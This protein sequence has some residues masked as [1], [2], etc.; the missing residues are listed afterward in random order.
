MVIQAFNTKQVDDAAMNAGLWIACPVNDTADPGMHDRSGTHGARLQC[1]EQLAARQTVITQNP[2]C[3]AQSGDFGMRCWIAL[4]DWRIEATSDN[5][6][7]QD[8]DS[9]DWHLAKTLRSTGQRNGLAHEEF[10]AEPGD[11]FLDYSHSIVAG[12]LPETS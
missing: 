5:L 2:C 12:G 11:G 4:T 1:H 8:H 3:I 10:V 7:I 9:T 6:A